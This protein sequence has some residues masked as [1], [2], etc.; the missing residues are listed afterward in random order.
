MLVWRLTP[1]DT[2]DPNWAA[3]SYRGLVIVRARDEDSAREA[4]QQTFG[5]KTRFPPGAGDI[6]PPWKRP[7]LVSAEAI[8]DPRYPAEGPGEVLFPV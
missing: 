4:A 7:Q 6:A 5:V 3:S 2:T 1:I 8:D